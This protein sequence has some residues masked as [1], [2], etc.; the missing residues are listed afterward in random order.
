LVLALAGALTLAGAIGAVSC[1]Q[2]VI[3][4]TVGNGGEVCVAQVSV[5]VGPTGG[6]V[7]GPDNAEVQIPAGALSEDITIHLCKLQS[8]YP[9]LPTNWTPTSANGVYGF[10]PHGTVF[11]KPVTIRVPYVDPGKPIR[12]V[13]AQ[14]DNVWTTVDGIP[15]SNGFA[16]ASLSHFSYFAVVSGDGAEPP[17]VA[18]GGADAEPDATEDAA[19]DSSCPVEG[20][21]PASPAIFAI[22][23]TGAISR[24]DLTPSTVVATDGG[25]GDGGTSDGG[26]PEGGASDG[27]TAP[28][29]TLGQFTAGPSVQL[30]GGLAPASLAMAS[31]A[32]SAPYTLYVGGVVASNAGAGAV[33]SVINPFGTPTLCGSFDV[34]EPSLLAYDSV[35]AE[36]W[37]SSGAPPAIS[38]WAGGAQTWPTSGIPISNSG[39][40]GIA[41]DTTGRVLYLSDAQFKVERWQFSGTG[42]AKQAVEL[43]PTLSSHLLQPKALAIAPWGE[44]LVV[45]ASTGNLVHFDL[46]GNFVSSTSTGL[47][48]VAAAPVQWP[49]GVQELLLADIA[50]GIFRVVLDAA[51][52]PIGGPVKVSSQVVTE[53]IAAP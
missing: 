15:V 14:P 41:L 2:N 45:D 34:P 48:L 29:V 10:E 47:N 53:M 51:H 37:I 17:P 21:P 33:T 35:D 1:K 3:S 31:T 44:L 19:E 22:S 6:D 20:G 8:G 28:S 18:D 5:A 13:T 7:I 38:T 32:G 36:L 12:L 26:T 16:T 46:S 39:F 11:Q 49:S 43:M 23:S 52:A 40:G 30:Q 9:A 27:G 25:A 50:Q 24:F 4:S 42:A